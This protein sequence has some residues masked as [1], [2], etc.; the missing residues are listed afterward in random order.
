[1]SFEHLYGPT[2][3]V[4]TKAMRASGVSTGVPTQPLTAA[5]LETLKKNGIE[6]LL[7]EPI[8]SI[9]RV[10]FVMPE[11]ELRLSATASEPG[12]KREDIENRDGPQFQAALIEHLNVVADLRI[13]AALLTRLLANN[14]RKDAV[15]AQIASLERQGY[16]K[17]D[18]TALTSHVTFVGGSIAV[19]GK[20]YVPT[21]PQ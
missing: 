17:R 2:L 19:N 16:I 7:H 14:A 1:M 9:S 8:I 11:G 3:A 13:D 6:L 20:P 12:L 15:N 21:P 18:G 10:G 4:M 5:A